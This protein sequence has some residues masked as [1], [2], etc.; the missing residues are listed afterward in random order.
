MRNPHFGCIWEAAVKSMKQY[1]LKVIEPNLSNLEEMY[2]LLAQI[3]ARLISRP[4]A[5][6]N[7]DPNGL[8]LTGENLFELP[9][10]AAEN[11]VSRK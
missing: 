10:G 7:T 3:E 5:P 9:D 2:T 1:L 8:N 4:L 11:N 6:I